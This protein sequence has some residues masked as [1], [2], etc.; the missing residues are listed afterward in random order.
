[1]KGVYFEKVHLDKTLAKGG[2]GTI[3]CE[4]KNRIPYA[5]KVKRIVIMMSGFIERA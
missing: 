1:M 3:A 2:T 4:F 5:T